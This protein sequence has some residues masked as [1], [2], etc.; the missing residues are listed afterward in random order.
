MTQEAR[1]AV[2]EGLELIVVVAKQDEAVNLDQSGLQH[3]TATKECS[4]L[5]GGS[6]PRPACASE[7]C[8]GDEDGGGVTEIS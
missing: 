5:C 3:L 2:E 1:F 8:A 7:L 6:R 4:Q